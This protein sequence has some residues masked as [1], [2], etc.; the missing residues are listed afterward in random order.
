[1]SGN[2]E[3]CFDYLNAT[4][5]KHIKL[6]LLDFWLCVL[7]FTKISVDSLLIK[8]IKEVA[9]L[10]LEVSTHFFAYTVRLL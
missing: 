1:M 4:A 9:F 8:V 6:E 3:V 2:V 10:T 5:F 7:Y